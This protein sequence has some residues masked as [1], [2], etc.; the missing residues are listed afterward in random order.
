MAPL[1]N[2]AARFVEPPGLSKGASTGTAPK[3][4][5]AN[6]SYKPYTSMLFCQGRASDIHCGLGPFCKHRVFRR[7][8]R[9]MVCNVWGCRFR[10]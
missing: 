5:V 1:G 7:L 2:I 8:I 9:C 10:I 4:Q 3:L 6:Y